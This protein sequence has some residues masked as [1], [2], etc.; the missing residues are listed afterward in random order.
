[1]PLLIWNTPL[2]AG[3]PSF[4]QRDGKGIR[5][6]K[7]RRQPT[8]V[9]DVDRQ[10]GD[11][12]CGGGRRG[13][14][15]WR[16]RRRRGLKGNARQQ[17]V[18]RLVD[19][20]ALVELEWRVGVDLGVRLGSDGQAAVRNVQRLDRG[21]ADLFARILLALLEEC[22]LD[23]SNDRA[24]Y[25]EQR[26]VRRVALLQRPAR[27]DGAARRQRHRREPG[28]GRS[29]HEASAVPSQLH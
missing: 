24:S 27:A 29:R 23:V 7:A 4:G 12:P 15:R 14:R 19:M 17:E 16:R 28:G 9:C 21:A 2:S 25:V 26:L 18:L 1:M 8:P 10:V 6:A 3:K 20:P 11:S 5:I 22:N 13:V